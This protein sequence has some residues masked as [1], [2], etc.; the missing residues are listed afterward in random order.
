MLALCQAFVGAGWIVNFSTSRKWVRRAQIILLPVVSLL[1]A[2]YFSGIIWAYQDMQAG[3]FP[4]TRI[5][6]YYVQWAAHN[7]LWASIPFA[8]ASFPLNLLGYS[9]SIAIILF[10]QKQISL[11]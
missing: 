8:I 4:E 1:L 11:V 10:T 6:L 2:G 5:L 7:G 3:F 9:A